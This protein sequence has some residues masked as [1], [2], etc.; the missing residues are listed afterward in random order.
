MGNV[1]IKYMFCRYIE[2]KRAVRKEIHATYNE[3]WVSG[4]IHELEYWLKKCGVDLS[5][6][7]IEPMICGEQEI[8]VL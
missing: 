2:K 7:R 6:E 1:D 3:A 5:Y 8:Q 4:E